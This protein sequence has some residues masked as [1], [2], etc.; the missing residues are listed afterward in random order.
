MGEEE[1]RGVSS[2]EFLA[3]AAILFVAALVLSQLLGI[4][5]L[6]GVLF[7]QSRTYWNAQ[8]YPLKIT[9]W[10]LLVANGTGGD[11]IYRTEAN[12]SMVLLNPTTSP[13][14]MQA[15]SIGPGN[16]SQ[17]YDLDTHQWLGPANQLNI[18]IEPGQKKGLIVQHWRLGPPSS[19]PL[20]ER[21]EADQE[22]QFDVQFTYA[23]R[24]E[25][26]SAQTA[27]GQGGILTLQHGSLPLVGQT[28]YAG[29]PSG[30]CPSGTSYCADGSCC[31]AGQCCGGTCKL[32][33]QYTCD[34]S[35]TCCPLSQTPCNGVCCPSSQICVNG[36][37]QAPNCTSPSFACGRFCCPDN[38]YCANDSTTDYGQA[39]VRICKSPTN[40]TC[41]QWCCPD[42]QTCNF[43]GA[44]SIDTA[45][46]PTCAPQVQTSCLGPN[47][48]ANCCENVS[49]VVCAN[50]SGT[51]CD[52]NVGMACN[53]LN[54][55][56]NFTACCNKTNQQCT[57][58]GCCSNPGGACTTNADCCDGWGCSNG[59]CSSCPAGWSA[60]CAQPTLLCN[61]NLS[62]PDPISSRNWNPGLYQDCCQHNLDNNG[63][64]INESCQGNWF[65]GT[66]FWYGC[67]PD[68]ML[69]ST[70]LNDTACA[71]GPYWYNYTNYST[72][73]VIYRPWP[74]G[75]P[76]LSSGGY[77]NNSG[78]CINNT[79]D[80]CNPAEGV[81]CCPGTYCGPD[82]KCTY[83]FTCPSNTVYIDNGDHVDNYWDCCPSGNVSWQNATTAVCCPNPSLMKSFYDPNTGALYSR[84][85]N[86][87]N[88]TLCGANGVCCP[89]GLCDEVSGTCCGTGM[90]VCQ[91]GYNANICCNSTTSNCVPN[92]GPRSY[93]A[94]SAC[95]PKGA[96]GNQT[97][98]ANGACCDTTTSGMV[99][100]GDGCCNTT[101]GSGYEICSDQ[102]DTC[103]GPSPTRECKNELSYTGGYPVALMGSVCCAGDQVACQKQCCSSESNCIPAKCPSINESGSLVMLDCSP[104]CCENYKGTPPNPQLC[105]NTTCC[106]G[107]S[108]CLQPSDGSSPRCCPSPDFGSTPVLCGGTGECCDVAGGSVCFGTV[109]CP[110]PNNTA[111]CAG[112]NQCCNQ[113][114]SQPGNVC[115]SGGGGPTPDSLGNYHCC[116]APNNTA[117]CLGNGMCCNESCKAG[118]LCC[119]SP[120]K[121]SAQ[122]P[123]GDYRCCPD[124]KTE[125]CT[126]DNTCCD[127]CTAG[128]DG[129]TYCCPA[130]N[131]KIY[132]AGANGQGACCASPTCT[133]GTDG[134]NYCC[135]APNNVSYC[136]GSPQCCSQNC[137]DGHC[138]QDTPP[139]ADPNGNMYSV[140]FCAGDNQ[141]C[142]H[143][144][145]S[146]HCCP[147]DTHGNLQDYV[148]GQCCPTDQKY[149]DSSAGKY[150]C[151]SG[152]LCNG[153]CCQASGKV[154]TTY[155]GLDG[156]PHSTCCPP[157]Q[158]ADASGVC[159]DSKDR[160]DIGGVLT[161]CPAAQQCPAGAPTQCCPSGQ[162]CAT[163]SD[164]FGN[165]QTK[166]CPVGQQALEGSGQCCDPAS[167][168]TVN[169][170]QICCD[171]SGLSACMVN[172]VEGTPN[173]FCCPLD[174]NGQCIMS[175]C[176]GACCD[177]S[178]D[179]I[180]KAPR[181]VCHRELTPP[182]CLPG[183]TYDPGHT[184]P[185]PPN[186]P[187]SVYCGSGG[188]TGST[189]YCCPPGTNCSDPNLDLKSC[190]VQ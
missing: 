141:C 49:S 68:N 57:T 73:G 82:N 107:A 1:R 6:Q 37:C 54:S 53:F 43:A 69:T 142:G 98:C 15:I 123:L 24:L 129:K 81:Y 59:V 127:H 70:C 134:Y 111:Y 118:D 39:C 76:S 56:G 25:S 187:G 31:G 100:T 137:I 157:G 12:L 27:A 143:T 104:K 75:C 85:C 175:V 58:G 158:V 152:S 139:D 140:V 52:L 91:T 9:D 135:A 149:Y 87:A 121:E 40:G 165:P 33:S 159:C 160:V 41:G 42:D 146:G 3:L 113:S 112:N 71:R 125:I 14:T 102:N 105:G 90:T 94:Y 16:F 51:C 78:C 110:P 176:G 115:C 119:T 79:W 189:G 5:P 38:Y 148:N 169:G 36:A 128:T 106:Y 7:S 103:C 10:A 188:M 8:A 155:T 162:S 144:C 170:N 48:T 163:Y 124:G 26:D 116:P 164:S 153:E 74:A 171:G 167:I 77:P 138:C 122:G 60:C 47:W 45:C 2:A 183:L 88:D 18:R 150:L 184:C 30:V 136:P 50:A 172:N 89:A 21:F 108:S 174:G 96:N 151:C 95:C 92:N 28:R 101:S 67:P 64:Y 35:C 177:E 34:A 93:G 83:P 166:C 80:Y 86:S 156:N 126:G 181:N 114:C 186:P 120:T 178:I 13:L 17:V 168:Q 72:D 147:F 99:C 185:T 117:Y 22:Y 161:C 132:C 84:C 182:Q 23:G 130:P 29:I 133:P 44:P 61:F 46:A 190:I 97:T 66:R 131:N 4:L 109:C 65:D 180:T 20:A 63:N 19:A 55:S 32:P 11:G 179:P 62:N 145:S 154:C 173:P